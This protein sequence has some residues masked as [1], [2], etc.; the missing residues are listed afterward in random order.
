MLLSSGYQV[1]PPHPLTWRINSI[2]LR[3]NHLIHLL[4]FSAIDKV[5]WPTSA[6]RFSTQMWGSN[7]LHSCAGVAL[8]LVL[9]PALVVALA[10]AFAFILKV[11]S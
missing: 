8:V 10:F 6:S 9:A 2:R 4:N 7:T 5:G 11:S 1:H 3:I